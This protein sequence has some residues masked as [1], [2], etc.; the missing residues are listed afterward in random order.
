MHTRPFPTT[1]F[2]QPSLVSIG[3]RVIDSVVDLLW[4]AVIPARSEIHMI[5]DVN[6][7]QRTQHTP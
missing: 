1:N 2:S 4:K 6:P 7:T 5:P 3:A